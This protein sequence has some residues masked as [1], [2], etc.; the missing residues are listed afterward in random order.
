MTKPVSEIDENGR[1]KIGANPFKRDRK[2]ELLLLKLAYRQ[3]LK[4]VLNG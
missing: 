1:P 4:N 2:F 3:E